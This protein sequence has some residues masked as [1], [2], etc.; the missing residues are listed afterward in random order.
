MSAIGL[1]GNT[2][3]RFCDEAQTA[4]VIN[5]ALD[6]GVNLIDTAESYGG[7]VSEEFVGK[8]IRGRRQ[9]VLLATKT[10]ALGEPAPRLTRRRII[11]RLD[12]S[13]RR[14]GTDYVDLYYLHFPDPL[15]PL[16]ES[17]RALEEVVASGKVVYPALSNYPAWQVAE[18]LRLGER[19]SWAPPV[20]LQSEYSLL[21]RGV[22][23]ELLPALRH[24]GLG[25]IPYSPLAGGF[26]TGKYR[27]GEPAPAGTRGHGSEGFERRW[28]TEA[29]FDRLDGWHEFAAGQGRSSA[30][31]ALSWLLAEPVVCSVIVGA[32]RPEQVEANVRA[33]EWRLSPEER[34]A[35]DAAAAQSPATLR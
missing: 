31:L 12:A 4:A 33:A 25:L 7:G 35:V 18:A 30:G 28:L 24:Y 17:L 9:E 13:L 20:L 16:E 11:E 5:R 34:A 10:G 8:A 26:L 15:T 23:A 27:R 22:E 21:N 6:L 2:F 1:G 14:L 19:G 29:N 3:G 32:T